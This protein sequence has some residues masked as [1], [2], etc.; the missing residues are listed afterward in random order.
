MGEKI[1]K[2]PAAEISSELLESPEEWDTN[3]PP[4]FE[5][6][7][8]KTFQVEIT[9]DSK[10]SVWREVINAPS[11]SKD[12]PGET[13]S[14]VGN[15]SEWTPERMPE[16]EDI[17]GLFTATV[18]VPPG[19]EGCFHIIADESDSLALYP[20]VDRCTRKTAE[21]IGPASLGASPEECC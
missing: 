5:E 21:I 13:F 8:G 12:K 16:S 10:Q 11:E 3:G 14:I 6:N 7:I 20:S 4:I 18:L 19:G 17:P 2:A 15:W 9:A 1:N